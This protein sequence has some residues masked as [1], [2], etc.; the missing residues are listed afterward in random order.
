MKKQ[1]TK[2]VYLILCLIFIN[3]F[4]INNISSLEIQ[5][6]SLN[7]P[8]QIRETITLEGIPT[9][10]ISSTITVRNPNNDVIVDYQNMTFDINS[11]DYY[12]NIPQSNITLSGLYPYCITAQGVGLSQTNCNYFQIT[13]TGTILTTSQAILYIFLLIFSLGIFLFFAY[14]S[15]KLPFS[16][17]YSVN[18]T[19]TR[20]TKKKYLKLFCIIFT[21]GFLSWT[22]NIFVGIFNNF[23]ELP[24]VYNLVTQLALLSW[25]LTMTIIVIIFPV[26]IIIGYWD[27][28]HSNQIKKWGESI[29]N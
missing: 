21:F 29:V 5:K 4:L 20:I 7:K 18:G 11:K 9:D 24:M 25:I 8:V 3:L 23:I 15:I 26:I 10:E 1:N 14:L 13:P 27:I 17:E 19:I 6:F 2:I 22:M 12:Y 16:N 28:Y